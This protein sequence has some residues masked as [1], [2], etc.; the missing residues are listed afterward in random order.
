MFSNRSPSGSH[1]GWID[2]LALV[3]RHPP[4]V[5]N[6]GFAVAGDA[7]LVA[8]AADAVEALQRKAGRIDL[9]VAGRAHLPPCGAW[10][11]ARGSSSRREYR[12]RCAGTLSGGGG[13]RR[14]QDAIENPRAAQHRRSRRAVGRHLQ[15]AGHRQHA[16]AMAIRR[17]HAS[18]ETPSH[19][20]RECRSALPAG[21]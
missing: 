19:R 15:H 8:P 21:R 12:D 4:A 14:A 17:Q 9:G 2:L 18:C 7:V 6:H 1:I 3:V 10:P 11:I 5:D 16:A 20:H 13:R